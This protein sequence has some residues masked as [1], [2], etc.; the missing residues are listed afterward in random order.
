[1]TRV[2]NTDLVTIT[3]NWSRGYIRWNP[4][5]ARFVK[6]GQLSGITT[7]RCALEDRYKLTYY[8][9]TFFFFF[10]IQGYFSV[11]LI[12]SVV[13]LQRRS[14]NLRF[15]WLLRR[16]CYPDSWSIKK[17]YAIAVQ[18]NPV[19]TQGLFSSLSVLRTFSSCASRPM[20]GLE[21]RYTR[22]FFTT[23]LVVHSNMQ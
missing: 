22:L 5:C 15:A 18:W 2:R 19:T 10:W 23:T 4:I 8:K 16:K 20:R 12:A 7:I 9:S 21:I 3:G 14:N 13:T 6:G 1:M 11:Q 17:W